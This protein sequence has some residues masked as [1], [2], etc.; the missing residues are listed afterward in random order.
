MTTEQLFQILNLMTMA[1]WLPLVLLPRMSWT[2]TAVSVT[3]R[4]RILVAGGR[5]GAALFKNPWALLAGWTQYL[6]FNLFI[7]GCEAREAKRR[8]IPHLLI[9]PVL[10]LTFLWGPQACWSIWRSDGWRS[11]MTRRRQYAL[12]RLPAGVEEW[13]ASKSMPDQIANRMPVLESY[14]LEGSAS[15]ISDYIKQVAS[16]DPRRFKQ[17]ARESAASGVWNAEKE[18]VP[19]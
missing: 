6:A 14:F 13:H 17:Y 3:E 9:V 10:V 7:G 12:Q 18:Q 4:G 16:R 11:L 8:G 5:E 19:R 2:S 15:C 1:A